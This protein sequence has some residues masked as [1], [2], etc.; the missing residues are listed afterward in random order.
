MRLIFA[1]T[2]EFAKTALAALIAANETILAV[3]TAPDKPA[4]RGQKLQMSAVKS[5]ALSHELPVYQ[6]T[7]LRDPNVQQTIAALKPDLMIVAAYGFILPTAV[8]ALPRLGCINIHASLLPKWRG[9]API[10]H[11]LLQGDAQT[12]ITMMQMDAGLDTGAILLQAPY[13]MTP[14]ETSATLFDRL[15][16]L[17]ATTL[18][19][20]L[21]KFNTLQPI[22]Q[23]E[24]LACYAPKLSK[25]DGL[26]NWNRTAWQ[27]DCQ[28]RALNPWPVAYTYLDDELVRIW[29]A[30]PVS[31]S[32]THAEPGTIIALTDQTICVA[33][34]DGVLALHE[35]QFA[36]GKRLPVSVI[37]QTKAEKFGLGRRF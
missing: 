10:Q 13:T 23:P 26:V 29:Q 30:K 27:L 20:T 1:G 12:G 24:E 17:G 25:I 4:G 3:Y 22:A 31:M 19:D 34:G 7:T 8:L 32:S 9:A 18:L 28:I 11:A 5:L 2:P 33:T 6:P 36:G 14:D 37:L 15:A 21:A 35:L 16:S